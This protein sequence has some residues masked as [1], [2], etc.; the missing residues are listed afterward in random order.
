[1]AK[2]SSPTPK[3]PAG[4][5]VVVGGALKKGLFRNPRT[6]FH[7]GPALEIIRARHLARRSTAAFFFFSLLSL[8]SFRVFAFK[9]SRTPNCIF[10]FSVPWHLH[11][12]HML[13]VV[14]TA[15]L[16]FFSLWEEH[17]ACY[18]VIG[19]C[20]CSGSLRPFLFSSFFC[21]LSL[22]VM[23][24]ISHPSSKTL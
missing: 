7:V 22:D 19:R 3:T 9:S 14:S 17:R 10:V 23:M 16:L 20:C 15:M 8:L 12:F 1:M 2:L 5:W 6:L 13:A 4:A 21:L 11:S 18:I 24:N